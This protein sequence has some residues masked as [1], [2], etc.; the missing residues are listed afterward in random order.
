MPKSLITPPATEPITLAEAKAHLRIDSSD[1]D[2]WINSAIISARMM[3][4]LYLRRYLITQTWMLS[5]DNE[6]PIEI[7]LTEGIQ[8]ISSV[9]IIARDAM[10]TII[11]SADYYLGAGKKKLYFDNVLSGH[12]IEI[13]YDVGYGSAVNVPDDIKQGILMHIADLYENRGDNISMS[14]SVLNLLFPHRI[15]YI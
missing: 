3:V 2:V 9:K 10:E 4:E 12:R 11:D 14:K 13:T 8:S 15:I 7:D 6:T 5:Y 1:E